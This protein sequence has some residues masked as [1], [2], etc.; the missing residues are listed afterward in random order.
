MGY[1]YYILDTEKGFV[2]I[3]YSNNPGKRYRTILNVN[4]NQ[5]ILLYYHKA[6]IEDEQEL[7]TKLIQ[8]HVHHEWYVYNDDIKNW[9]QSKKELHGNEIIYMPRKDVSRDWE[10][11]KTLQKV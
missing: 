6:T 11:I 7:H 5:L 3:G 10:K 4:N 2:K 1:I 9:I 8:Y